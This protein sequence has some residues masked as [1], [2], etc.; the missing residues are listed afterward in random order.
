MLVHNVFLCVVK[1]FVCSLFLFH[2]QLVH[3]PYIK[4]LCSF[5]VI[6][7]IVKQTLIENSLRLQVVIRVLFD[8]R[9]ECFNNVCG[10]NSFI[11]HT[12]HVHIHFI[13]YN[14][15]IRSCFKLSM[16][17]VTIFLYWMNV[18]RYPMKYNNSSK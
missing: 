15:I 11:I 1:V 8:V 13:Y 2:Y 4:F 17:L 6:L 5:I 12:I 18:A 16:A 7:Y 10:V 9:N 3:I 14:S